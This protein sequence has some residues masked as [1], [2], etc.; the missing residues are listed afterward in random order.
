MTWVVKVKGYEETPE[1]EFMKAIEGYV[2]A[3]SNRY[4]IEGFDADDLAQELRMHL[5]RKMHLYNP[6]KGTIETWAYKVMVNRARD[7]FKRTDPLCGPHC[8][9]PDDFPD[10]PIV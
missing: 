5:W 2:I 8:E 6:R 3:T 9:I 10:T 1:E 4:W 7:L